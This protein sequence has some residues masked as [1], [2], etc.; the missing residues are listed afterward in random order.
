MLQTDAAINRGNSGG[1]LIDLEGKV[2]GI[3]SAKVADVGVE[4]LGFSIPVNHAKPIIQSLLQD[5]KV[6]RPF[7]GISF[8]DL[9]AYQGSIKDL[10][11]PDTV[12]SGL[13]VVKTSGPASAAGLQANDVIVALDRQPVESVL[14]LR[15]Y[16]Y[17]DKKIG[18]KLKVTY[19]R[20][21]KKQSTE[22]TLAER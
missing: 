19:Y 18:Q 8:I 3:N 14:D 11:L 7:I 17:H 22:L 12:K 20:D 16:L 4:G 15:N 5:G 1:A 13:V 2:I 21:G 9:K 6:K 10:H